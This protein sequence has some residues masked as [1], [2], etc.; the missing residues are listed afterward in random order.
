MK[1]RSILIIS[2]IL[3]ISLLT[4]VFCAIPVSA[5]D[6]P[7]ETVPVTEISTV[8]GL[9]AV[10]NNLSG[11]YKLTADID[12]GGAAWT[13]F[14]EFNGTFDGNGKTI[15]NFTITADSSYGQLYAG[16]F[17]TVGATGIVKNVKVAKAT[18][19]TSY[20]TMTGAIAGR[21]LVGSVISGCVTADDVKVTANGEFTGNL[22]LG[23]IVGH[24][25]SD[26]LEYCEN[27]ATVTVE[28]SVKPSDGGEPGT[29]E[30]LAGGITGRAGV[31]LV[32]YCINNGDVTI[33]DY[34][35][36]KGGWWTCVGGI[37]G[38]MNPWAGSTST[39]DHCINNGTVSNLFESLATNSS[40]SGVVGMTTGSNKEITARTITNCFNF[41][42]VVCGRD[43]TIGQIVAH[44]ESATSA[45]VYEGNY[46]LA[47]LYPASPEL[48]ISE[49]Y[50][51][52][53]D[54]ADNLKATDSFKSIVSTMAENMM[55]TLSTMPEPPTAET[56][57]DGNG[58]GNTDGSQNN[59]GNDNGNG[60]TNEDDSKETTADTEEETT[61]ADTTAETATDEE[62]TG[63]GSSVSVAGVAAIV[64][65]GALACARRKKEQ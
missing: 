39:I 40:A 48:D 58:S 44:M 36:K 41:G 49:V 31:G 8:D 47:N 21:S 53:F 35:P 3:V 56:P 14:G 34:S 15:S 7:A 16:L 51:A 57:D 30:T 37:A 52:T 64:A 9:K 24:S 25:Y 62:A 42:E 19:T 50:I 6:T 18:I 12:L 23:G 5:D 26:R 11:S 38:L 4:S 13:P 10:A 43:D 46:A 1:K 54:T 28:Y 17:S 22:H 33:A 63:C 59:G 45:F 60:S 55:F 32:Q 20:S 2:A 61:A 27:N 65:V 29:R